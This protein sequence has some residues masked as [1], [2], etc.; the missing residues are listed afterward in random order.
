[1][2]LISV[3][4]SAARIWERVKHDAFVDIAAVVQCLSA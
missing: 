1:V 2:A 3:E 4:F